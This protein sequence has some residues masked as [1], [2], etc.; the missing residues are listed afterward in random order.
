MKKIT[1][2]MSL[3]PFKKTDSDYIRNV[4]RK[5]FLQWMPLLKEVNEI[6]VMLWTADGSEIL[7][8]SG[9]PDDKFEW[10]CYLGTANLALAGKQDR[11]DLSLHQK[12]R[13]YTDNPPVMTYRILK[14]IVN[15][16]KEEGS[17]SFRIVLSA[18]EIHLI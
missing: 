8:Y 10:C 17:K 5:M 11:P 15:I 4:C 18:S 16:L 13:F 6:K 3:K 1:L 12:K 7:D 2:E 14:N 9:N